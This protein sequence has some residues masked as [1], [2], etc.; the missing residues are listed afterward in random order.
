MGRGVKIRGS[1]RGALLPALLGGFLCAWLP[2]LLLAQTVAPTPP[3][4][5]PGMPASGAPTPGVTEAEAHE[6][7]VHR[8]PPAYPDA[9][10]AAH[11]VGTVLFRITIDQAGHVARVF[12]ISG[13]V[14]LV[15]PAAEAVRQWRYTPFAVDGAPTLV[16]TTV[17]VP[18]GEI[19]A[20][21]EEQRLLAVYRPL[22][23]S[24]AELVRSGGEMAQQVSACRLAA[25]Q[26]AQFAVGTRPVERRQADEY[27]ATALSRSGNF[28]GAIAWAG[29]AIP[30][31]K[32][33]PVDPSGANTAYV[34]MAQAL[35]ASGDMPGAIGNLREAEAGLR[36]AI[37]NAPA[38][39]PD[40][41][42]RYV[43]ALRKS[44]EFHAGLLTLMIK[45]GEARDKRHEAD[46][47]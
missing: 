20:Q 32:E 14:V 29:K 11:I 37:A 9:A 4:G 23:G 16:H 1:L 44:L 38:P 43:D 28:A 42:R 19:A 36:E 15:E 30:L 7:L 47:L 27:Y 21:A 22:W 13:P 24:C 46:V 31:F 26:A 35:A 40:V 33:E 3:S 18:F 45:P 17:H 2:A 12:P 6:H 8:V 10:E 34:L 41:K 39:A 25:G 5:V